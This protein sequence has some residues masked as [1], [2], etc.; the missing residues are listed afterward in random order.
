MRNLPPDV[1]YI[2]QQY[3]I[4][5]IQLINYQREALE[6]PP[7]EPTPSMKWLME[8]PAQISKPFLSK[9]NNQP[10]QN[11]R[12]MSAIGSYEPTLIPNG[13]GKPIQDVS[14]K[15]SHNPGVMAGLVEQESAFDSNAT[16][17]VG[18]KGLAQIMQPALTDYN[19]ANGTSFTMSDMNDSATNLEVGGWYL[20]H[21]QDK[22]FNGDLKMALYAYNFGIG[23][24][25]RSM[26]ATGLPYMQPVTDKRGRV[27]YVPNEE[28]MRY[29]PGVMKRAAKYGYIDA[30]RDPL[31]HR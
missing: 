18:A 4:H 19:R 15:H 3:Q 6:L 26:E 22:F 16:S 25:R 7:I 2:A 10:F 28:A 14:T 1:E 24:V 27:T 12:N 9:T 11:T 30:L 13:L 31:T 20:R 23:N 8:S 21:L 17:P 5:P 29:A